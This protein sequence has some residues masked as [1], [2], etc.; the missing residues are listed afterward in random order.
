MAEL[1]MINQAL[2]SKYLDISPNVKNQ[3]VNNII[4]EMQDLDI[5]IALGHP[6]YY[7]FTRYLSNTGL[8]KAAITTPATSAADNTYTNITVLIASGEGASAKATCVVVGGMVTSIVITSPGNSFLIG[9]TFNFNEL[10]GALFTVTDFYDGVVYYPGIPQQYIDLYEGKSYTDARG[11]LVIYEG[12]TLSMVYFWMAR[13]TESDAYRYTTTGPVNK[14]HDNATA[15]STAAI[16]KMVQNQRSK[17]NAHYNEVQKFLY[18]NRSN[19]PLWYYNGKVASARQAGPRIRSID[20]TNFNYPQGLMVNEMIFGGVSSNGGNSKY[21]LPFEL[22]Y[23]IGT[24]LPIII[25]NFNV[26]YPQYSNYPGVQIKLLNGDDITG[27]SSINTGTENPTTIIAINTNNNG[28]GQLAS[29]IKVI[30]KA[31]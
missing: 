3:R 12:M 1:L 4:K 27:Q 8:G 22:D 9:D 23:D 16:T 10:P 19:F 26:K 24:Q 20:R 31:S 17:A 14:T 30:I 18:D 13:F 21:V 28:S 15:L 25:D 2:V 5:R 6:L 29:A 7:D 11:N